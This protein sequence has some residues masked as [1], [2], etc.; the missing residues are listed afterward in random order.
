MEQLHAAVAPHLAST[1]AAGHLPEG[2][3]KTLKKLV[4]HLAKQERA[5]YKVV[6]APKRVRKA[7]AGELLASL[8]SFLKPVDG[9]EDTVSKPMAKTI[10][11]LAAQ[12]DKSRRKQ[13][14]QA[15]KAARA[16]AKT[17]KAETSSKAA[18]LWRPNV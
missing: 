16:V 3:A 9:V 8:D 18:S 7:L 10:K 17:P 11:R 6:N 13:A 15:A 4:K 14:K 2:V 12:L 5:A 1:T